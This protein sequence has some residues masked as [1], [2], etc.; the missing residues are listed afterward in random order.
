[1][2]LASINLSKLLSA[3]L[4][5]FPAESARLAPFA[6][7]LTV[8]TPQSI[9]LR[10]T[11]PG[12]ITASAFVLN[13]DRLLLLHHLKLNR[14]LQPGGHV[15]HTDASL[16]AAAVREVFEE[17]GIRQADLTLIPV[18]ANPQVPL[19]IDIHPIPANLRKGEPAHFHHDFRYL[20]LHTGDPAITIDANESHNFRWQ[21]LDSLA[22][23]PDFAGVVAKIR[24]LQL[25]LQTTSKKGPPMDVRM[26]TV[27]SIRVAYLRDHGP[28]HK[29]FQTLWPRFVPLAAQR[30]LLRPGARTL[31]I[32]QDSNTSTP[33]EKL[34]ADAAVTIDDSFAGDADLQVQT[35]PGGKFAVGTHAGSYSEL[36]NSWNA[37]CGEG[38]AKKGLKIRIAACFEIYL[39]DPRTTPEAELRTELYLPIE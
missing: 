29:V 27:A 8:T 26:E 5:R 25:H 6:Q 16:P 23:D 24:D 38:L 1:M 11:S 10:S 19:D 20:F 4:A 18:A 36:G 31:S 32:M 22:A 34:R 9:F 12:H 7:L 21:P 28:Y 35:L 3:Y 39:N 2:T 14:W 17:T 33:P 13:A 37:L 30:G 15:E